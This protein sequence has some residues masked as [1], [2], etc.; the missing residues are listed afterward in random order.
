MGRVLF[1]VVV[2]VAM[3]LI[4]AG[5]EYVVGTSFVD[6][7]TAISAMESAGYTNVQV[8]GRQNVFVSLLGCGKED[9]VKF[10]MVAVNPNG[11]T[12]TNTYVCVGWPWKGATIRFR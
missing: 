10:D 8:V 4:V 3:V 7:Q 9:S 5:C 1:Y 2:V 12:V 6:Q 11:E